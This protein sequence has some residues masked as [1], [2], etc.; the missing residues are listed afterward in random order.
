MFHLLHF[1][2]IHLMIMS[3]WWQN[4]SLIIYKIKYQKENDGILNEKKLF[5]LTTVPFIPKN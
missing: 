3:F 4:I 1:E 2:I 5:Y